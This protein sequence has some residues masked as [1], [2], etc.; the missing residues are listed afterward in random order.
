MNQTPN[1]NIEQIY[2]KKHN[3][4]D[5]RDLLISDIMELRQMEIETQEHEG[6]KK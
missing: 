2:L 1:D 3:Q 6:D 5:S 4:M